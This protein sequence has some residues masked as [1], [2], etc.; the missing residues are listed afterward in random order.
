LLKNNELSKEFSK[1]PLATLA[2]MLTVVFLSLFEAGFDHNVVYWGVI[3]LSI[4]AFYLLVKGNVTIDFSYQ[5][6]FLWYSLF[7]LWAGLS[8]FWSINPHRTLVEFI[9]LSLYWLVFLLATTLTEDSVLRLGRITIITAAGVAIFGISQFAILESKRMISTFT[10]PNPL[11][12]YLVMVFMISWGYFIR[13]KNN[14]YYAILILLIL[15]ALILTASRGSFI[16][17][18]ISLPLLFIG[19]RKSELVIPVVKTIT[20]IIVALIISQIIIYIAPYLQEAIGSNLV[21]SQFLTRPQSFIELS[22]LGRLSYWIT[23]SKIAIGKPINGYG[24]G[25]FFM[26]Y[27]I[28]YDGGRWYSRFAHS[29]FVQTAAELGFIGLGLLLALFLTLFRNAWVRIKNTDYPLYLP[30]LTA[31]A[32]SFFINIGG[33]FNWNF[34]GSAIIFFIIAGI[35]MKNDQLKIKYHNKYLVLSFVTIMLGLTVWQLSANLL[36]SKGIKLDFNGDIKKAAEIYDLANT[37]YPVNSMSYVFA[38]NNYYLLSKEENTEV[39]FTASIERFEKAIKLSPYDA[40]IH[41]RLA[42]LY[43]ELGDFGAAEKHF[44]ESV[45]YAAYRLKLFNDFGWF[46]IKQEKNEDALKILNKGNILKEA[47]IDS[48]S[49]K[50]DLEIVMEQIQILEQLLDIAGNDSK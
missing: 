46:Y 50:D 38:G 28:E 40:N 35:I 48:A 7:L 1:V 10:N 20:F 42:W 3:M 49:T 18:L 19:F 43:W 6:P 33:D 36:Y 25:T 21:L 31:A 11:G 29:H 45:E 39:N 26:A 34:P 27:F 9:Q 4:V 17:F 16:C 32:L 37:L 22:G 41:N 23:G 15:V 14:S 44:N 2:L 47:A 8:V 30:G 13:K 5:K 12:I 24:L